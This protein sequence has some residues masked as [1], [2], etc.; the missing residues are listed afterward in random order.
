[1]VEL[2]LSVGLVKERAEAARLSIVEK[3]R[4]KVLKNCVR[5]GH[6]VPGVDELGDISGRRRG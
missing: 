1:M 6:H 4:V 5:M 3:S 2:Y